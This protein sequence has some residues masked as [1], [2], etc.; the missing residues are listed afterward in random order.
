MHRSGTSALARA[1]SFA[2]FALP[3]DLM[4]PQPDNPKGFWEST[5]LVRLNEEILAGL[6][7]SWREAAPWYIPGCTL[8]A[9]KRTIAGAVRD[10]W[11]ARATSL[12]RDVFGG[13]EAIVV[14]DPRICLF[15]P[16]WREALQEAGYEPQFILI[17]RNPIDVAASL[18]Q[19]NGIA[20]RAGLQL[21]Q[22]YV[23]AALDPA[24]GVVPDAVMAYEDLLKLPIEAMQRL[25]ERL[26]MPELGAGETL[27]GSIVSADRHHA[28]GDAAVGS[29]PI[30]SGQV[31]Q[32][33]SLLSRWDETPS[34]TRAREI[35]DLCVTFED[36]MLL[37]GPLKAMQVPAAPK[38]PQST[39]A[40]PATGSDRVPA[41][42]P[43]I[44]HYHLF[45]N[46]GT[47]VDAMLKQNFGKR[48]EEKEFKTPGARSNAAAVETFLNSRP[49]LHAFSSHTAMLPLPKLAGREVFPIIFLRHPVSR[50]K[51]AYDFERK[52]D[53]DTFGARLAK[54]HD[55]AGYLRELLES[56]GHR[57][58]RN[59]QTCRL[60]FGM[61]RS[62]GSELDRARATLDTLP[63]CGLVEEYDRSLAL[64]EKFLSPRI[65]DFRAI[66]VRKNITRGNGYTLA[67]LLEQIA[68]E[69]GPDLNQALW[70][71]N[72]DDMTL[73]EGVRQRYERT[74]TAS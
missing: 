47:S 52:Q 38:A 62:Y 45:K 56:P 3:N 72:A 48:W 20:P 12:V 54:K 23:L 21:W 41:P 16:L 65:P 35:K 19:R 5:S 36:S 33:W 46:A 4:Q 13:A 63:F 28:N 15:L 10:A 69:I 53:V 71:A 59:F 25:S 27:H 73:F 67:D 34:E 61:P 6:G 66:A 17:H 7:S 68:D 18:R 43:L 30:V 11:I 29:S 2:G 55:F 31:K 50:L 64:L 8:E 58:A 9:A 14:K 42:P 32:A 24:S 1:L 26:G 60:A 74:D 57:Q 22:R 40:D 51:S 49:D 44:L 39:A 70:D 37:C